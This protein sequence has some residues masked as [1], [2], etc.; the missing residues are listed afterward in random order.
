MLKKI[1]LILVLLFLASALCSGC[2][3]TGR[4]MG[5]AAKKTE[6]AVEKID[7]AA[8]NFEKGYKDGAN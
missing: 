1:S 5:K 8:D 3:K 2:Y 6:Q 7:N 4:A